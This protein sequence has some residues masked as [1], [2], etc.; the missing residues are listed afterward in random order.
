MKT[1]YLLATLIAA[2]FP[3]TA[4]LAEDSAKTEMAGQNEDQKSAAVEMKGV[5]MGQMMSDA[6]EATPLLRQRLTSRRAI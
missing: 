3:L 2:T 5:E 6:K 1:T 4:V